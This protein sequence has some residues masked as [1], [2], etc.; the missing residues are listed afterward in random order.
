MEAITNPLEEMEIF[1]KILAHP[2]RLKIAGLLASE[3]L[4]SPQIAERLH[5]PGY[6]VLRCIEMLEGLGLVRHTV[7]AVQPP[8]RNEPPP[9]YS[10]DSDALLQLSKRVLA[11]SRPRTKTEDFE[12][13]AFEKKVLKDFMTPDGRLKS[14]PAQDKKFLVIANFLVKRFEPGQRYTEKQVNQI[15]QQVYA[16]SA[17]LRRYLVDK[18]LMARQDGEYWR[19]AA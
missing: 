7:P 8:A 18:G 9:V 5:I 4:T 2:E 12:G 14:I 6:D 11:N 16:D 17:T 13:E 1:F 19:L 3:P 10:L 15:L